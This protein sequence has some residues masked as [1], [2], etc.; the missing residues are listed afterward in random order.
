MLAHTDTQTCTHRAEGTGSRASSEVRGPVAVD[1]CVD[2]QLA[3][4][5]K[6]DGCELRDCSG[7]TSVSLMTT[8]SRLSLHFP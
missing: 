2:R 6:M 3:G 5:W 7:R 8:F 4:G 1:G